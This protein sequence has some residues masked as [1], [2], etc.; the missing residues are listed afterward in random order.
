MQWFMIGSAWIQREFGRPCIKGTRITV[1][2]VF[3]LLGKGWSIEKLIGEYPQL[4]EE[5]IRAALS[6][7]A[8]FLSQGQRRKLP[9]AQLNFV[10][11]ECVNRSLI[12][13]L[14]KLEHSVTAIKEISQDLMTWPS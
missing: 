9:E 7:G 10:V 4:T 1:E 3:R 14:R 6:Y 2:L 8:D 12:Q 5:D 11:D 13:A